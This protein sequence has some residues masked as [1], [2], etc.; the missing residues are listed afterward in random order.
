MSTTIVLIITLVAIF[1]LYRYI[2]RRLNDIERRLSN[3]HPTPDTG[4]GDNY[5]SR[6]SKK[7]DAIKELC[8]PLLLLNIFDENDSLT[9][10]DD[11]YLNWLISDFEKA[12]ETRVSKIT[13][14]DNAEKEELEKY[15]KENPDK[16]DFIPSEYLKADILAASAGIVVRQAIY[17]QLQTI[18]EIFFDVVS[19]KLSIK[20]ARKKA[21]EVANRQDYRELEDALYSPSS[22]NLDDIDAN[23]DLKPQIK[24]EFKEFYGMH[25]ERWKNGKWKER[26]KWHK[27][28]EKYEKGEADSGI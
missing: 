1:L 5:L 13:A 17:K 8:S 9:V 15:E 27:E 26:L 18:K 28:M 2:D 6:I 14:V 10:G 23:A 19:G 24:K 20:E 11:V 4:D 22:Y 3:N 16:K 7:V 21:K 25:E 12:E